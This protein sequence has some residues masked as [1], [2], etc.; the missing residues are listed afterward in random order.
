[1]TNKAWTVLTQ[2]MFE[3]RI[4]L[5]TCQIIL[6]VLKLAND[7]NVGW[8]WVLT[9]TWLWL[10]LAGTLTALY[11]I[12][13]LKDKKIGENNDKELIEEDGSKRNSGN[14]LEKGTKRSK[15]DSR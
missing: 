15:K 13:Y 5:Q 14:S 8:F 9:P 11:F 6:V 1:M 2:T 4:M 12:L 10:L 3:V 7:L